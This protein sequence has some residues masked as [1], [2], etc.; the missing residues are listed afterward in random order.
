MTRTIQANRVSLEELEK[1]FHIQLVE[2]EHFFPEWQDNLPVISTEEQKRLDRVKASYLNLIKHP[3]LL[4]N[5]VKMV[6][7]SPLLD[8]AGFYLP[9]FHIQSEKSVEIVSEDEGVVVKGQIDV[10]AISAQLWVLVIESKQAAFS[11]EVGIPQ[12]LAY[13]FSNPNPTQPTFGLLINGSSCRF[14][15]LTRGEA[16]QYGVSR[17]FDLLNPGNDLY[18]VLRILRSLNQLMVGEGKTL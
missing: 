18:Q 4:E 9:P 15:K 1:N 6:V 5:S 14:V 11:L 13:M 2:D 16:S 10:L 8:L 7:L 12:L 3:P 17:G